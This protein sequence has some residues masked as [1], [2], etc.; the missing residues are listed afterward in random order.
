[1]FSFL[2]IAQFKAPVVTSTSVLSNICTW[3]VLSMYVLF[4]PTYCG[5]CCMTGIYPS[6]DTS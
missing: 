2:Y 3:H 5:R 1:M 6:R 4:W